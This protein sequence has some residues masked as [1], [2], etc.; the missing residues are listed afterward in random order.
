MAI[1]GYFNPA[2]RLTSAPCVQAAIDFPRL[3]VG[4]R[5]RFLIDTGS[6]NTTPHLSD[7]TELGIDHR[8]LNPDS[9]SYSSGIGGSMGYYSEPAWLL[10]VEPDGTRQFCELDINICE[11]TNEPAAQIL[12]SLL[13]RDFLNLC[14]LTVDHFND[15]IRLEPHNVIDS[16]VLPP[17]SHQ[18]PATLGESPSNPQA[19]ATNS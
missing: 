11:A 7:V 12:P 8:S 17:T 5:I 3:R 13:V 18:P 9:K 15:A 6:Y 19:A 1:Q 14:A 4:G 2:N 10:F 16:F